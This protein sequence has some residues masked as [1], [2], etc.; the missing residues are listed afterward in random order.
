MQGGFLFNDSIAGNIAVGDEQI[1]KGRLEEAARLANVAP[2]VAALPLG[3]NT[4]IGANGVGLSTGQKQR[5]LIARALYRNPDFLFFDE[6]TSALDAGN[7]QQITRNMR[8]VFKGK[9]VVVIAHRLSTVRHADK[10]VVL[11][12]GRITEVG[13]HEQL[14][15]QRGIHYQLVSNQLELGN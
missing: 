4:R 3:Y 13:H 7:E 6:A 15:N 10:I 2:F 5:I 8:E 12:K 14:V 9:T 1:D 11:D